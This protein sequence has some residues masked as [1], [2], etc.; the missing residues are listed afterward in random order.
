MPG[1]KGKKTSKADEEN[2]NLQNVTGMLRALQEK[3]DHRG[4]AGHPHHQ[5]QALCEDEVHKDGDDLKPETLKPGGSSD[6]RVHAG[7]GRL[8]LR[9]E[10][11]VSK[12][13][14]GG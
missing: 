9:C 2:Q 8:F 12:G 3:Q 13:R 4:S 14:H 7:S 6:R 11:P 1:R 5:Y 10:C